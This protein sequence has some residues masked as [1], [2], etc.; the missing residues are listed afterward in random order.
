[1]LGGVQDLVRERMKS[2]GL[3]KE[4]KDV[5]NVCLVSSF[6]PVSLGGLADGVIYALFY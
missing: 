5:L 4:F 2:E 6:R 1:M 3:Y